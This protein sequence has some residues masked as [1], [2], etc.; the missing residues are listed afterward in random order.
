MTISMAELLC[1]FV[2]SVF[3]N[4]KEAEMKKVDYGHI[5]YCEGDLSIPVSFM[6]YPINIR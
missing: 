4:A 5:R 2:G 1:L 6:S 3:Q